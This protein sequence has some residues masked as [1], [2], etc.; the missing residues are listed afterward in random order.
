VRRAGTAG[1][2]ADAELARELGVRHGHE[3]AHLLVAGLDEIDPAVAL[4]RSNDSVD[5]V[6]RIAIDSGDAPILEALDEE[7][8]CFHEAR[9][10]P[11]DRR[12]M[13]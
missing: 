2:K 3:R 8:G 11:P 9:T 6:A 10:P 7:V 13:K 1:S 4:K 12:S 5:A